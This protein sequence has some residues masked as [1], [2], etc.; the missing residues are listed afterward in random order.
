MIV[1]IPLGGTGERFKKAGYSQQKALIPVEG[2]AIIFWLLDE[3]C[4]NNKESLSQLK[5]VCIPYI[6][7]YA[8][9]NLE[10]LLTKRYSDISFVFVPLSGTTRGAAETVLLGL[11]KLGETF[12]GH[13]EPVLCLDSDNFYTCNVLKKW[14]G[15]NCVFSFLDERPEAIFSYVEVNEESQ[16]LQIKEKVK[17]SDYANCGGY[18][19]DSMRTLHDFCAEVIERNIRDKNEFYISTVIRYMMEKK[20]VF[21]M[22]RVANKDY[23]SLGTPQLVQE[24]E[25]AFLLDLDGTLVDSNPQYVR[26][27]NKLLKPYML[28]VDDQFFHH[29]I[30]GNSDVRFLKF[31]MPNL[32]TS[33]CQEISKKK[34]SLFI[35]EITNAGIEQVLIPGVKDFIQRIKNSRIAVVTSSNRSSALAVLEHTGLA[36]YINVVVGA[37]D[38]DRHKPSP[39]PFLK[40]MSVLCV[41]PEVCTVFEDSLTGYTSAKHAS[42]GNICVYAPD[43]AIGFEVDPGFVFASYSALSYDKAIGS[44]D[45]KSENGTSLDSHIN[46]IRKCLIRGPVKAVSANSHDLLKTGYICDITSFTLTHYGNRQEKVVLKISNFGNE[47]ARV[48]QQLDMYSKEAYFYGHL[49]HLLGQDIALPKYFGQFT[50]GTQV[51][52]LLGDL[53]EQRGSFNLDLNCDIWMLMN[54]VRTVHKMHSRYT[55][56]SAEDVIAPM[57]S[58]KKIEEVTYYAQLV[59]DRFDKFMHNNSRFLNEIQVD[60]MTQIKSN[61]GKI[62][63]HQSQFPLSFCHGDLKSPNIYYPAEGEVILLDWQYIHLNKGV[64]DIVFLLVESI[65]Y[66]PKRVALVVD[67]YFELCKEDNPHL[68]RDDFMFDFKCALCIF[69]F[70]V[71]IWFNSEDADKLLDKAFPLRFMK[72]LLTYYDAYLDTDFFLTL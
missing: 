40:A 66:D 10:S 32:T 34:D 31:L 70:F 4:K 38:I 7:E 24:F 55:F 21:Y 22:G 45:F 13:D 72:T 35:E 54:V 43:N 41:G 44:S 1:L 36:E 49:S 64:S 14:G 65:E 50:R 57:A 16:I 6:P 17:I 15:R 25:R 68:T 28:D 3:F 48:A 8:T 67:F 62:L 69:P 27:W 23:Y 71:T 39:D 26:V 59:N 51:G 58:L 29:F 5:C 18:G 52:I 63:H 37:E 20:H 47:L 12:P 33:D 56:L 60:V 9:E 42:P 2:K 30:M 53:R 19:F 11:N 61:Y 46:A